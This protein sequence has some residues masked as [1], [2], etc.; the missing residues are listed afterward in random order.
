MNWNWQQ[1]MNAMINARTQ[2]RRTLDLFWYIYFVRLY[3]SNDSFYV[4][5]CTTTSCNS[6]HCEYSDMY[7]C[8]WPVLGRSWASWASRGWGPPRASCKEHDLILPACCTCFLFP[9]VQL[10][11]SF[12]CGTVTCSN[13]VWRSLW[14]HLSCCLNSCW[15]R[16]FYSSGSSWSTRPA[17]RAWRVWPKGKY[18]V[19]LPEHYSHLYIYV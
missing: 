11:M 14:K 1:I 5:I 18:W 15:L 2:L 3:I 6:P 19:K 9:A 7:L 10:L 4:Q 12:C 13:A 8:V 16:T 17:R